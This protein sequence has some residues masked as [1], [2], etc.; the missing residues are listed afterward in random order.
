MPNTYYTLQSGL[1]FHL[2]EGVSHLRPS[3]IAIGLCGPVPNNRSVVELPN[4]SGY[5]RVS[6]A[7]GSTNWSYQNDGKVYNNNVIT[8]PICSG[9][10]G[11]TFGVFVADNSTY[12][13]GNILFYNQHSVAAEL[14]ANS[15]VS[16]PVSGL[17]ITLT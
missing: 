7:P 2:F 16:Y 6:V 9:Y 12:G 4:Q 17:A 15:Q 11:W 13:A 10:V 3:S 5:A 14:T 1:M 8:F